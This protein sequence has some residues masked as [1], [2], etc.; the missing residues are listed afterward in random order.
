MDELCAC[1]GAG[2]GWMHWHWSS[3]PNMN[4]CSEEGGGVLFFV[5]I[6]PKTRIS[7]VWRR[8][9]KTSCLL[10]RFV[11]LED[12]PNQ[13]ALSRSQPQGILGHIFYKQ[14]LWEARPHKLNWA[15]N[16][17]T[18]NA[19]RKGFMFCCLCGR[20]LRKGRCHLPHPSK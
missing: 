10:S 11:C 7:L 19:F 15:G 16:G 20:A 2:G 12:T 1:L 3:L 5:W 18:L 6:Y 17:S 13:G 4:S 8:W 14:I 9:M